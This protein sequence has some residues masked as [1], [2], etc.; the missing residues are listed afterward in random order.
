[1]R[2][3]IM[4]KWN[5]EVLKTA[6]IEAEMTQEAVARELCRRLETDSVTGRHVSEWERKRGP[7]SI[8]VIMALAS[9]LHV[10]WGTFYD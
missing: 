3:K 8:H 2:G 7:T 4:K 6:R 9:V 5:P 10:K 1:M